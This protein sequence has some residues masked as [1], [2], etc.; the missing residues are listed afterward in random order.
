MTARALFSWSE[1]YAVRPSGLTAGYSGSRS[2]AT[3]APGPKMRTSDVTSAARGP[4]ALEQPSECLLVRAT[5]AAARMPFPHSHDSRTRIA[6]AVRG[7]AS[8]PEA[9]RRFAVHP[10]TVRRLVRRERD[11]GSE[12]HGSMGA[13]SYADLAFLDGMTAHHRMA[14]DMAA[15]A[16]ERAGSDSVRALARDIRIS[17]QAEI[18]TMAAWRARWFP[19]GPAPGPR[20]ADDIASMGLAGRDMGALGAAR[21][22]ASDRLF[23]SQMI[24]HHAGALTMAA[25]AGV[26]SE[27]PEI[28]DLAEAVVAAQAREIGEMQAGLSR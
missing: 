1:T 25:E 11:T 8:A 12:D 21:G 9:A 2:C 3:L 5:P 7:G 16:D 26:R 13:S 14:P 28:R 24:P 20:T 4:P 22:P 19:D 17:Q 27:R 6:A 15:L 23:L 10:T 18:D